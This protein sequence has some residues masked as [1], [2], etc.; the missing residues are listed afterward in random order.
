V[1]VDRQGN[2]PRPCAHAMTSLSTQGFL[3]MEQTAAAILTDWDAA[4][5]LASEATQPTRAATVAEALFPGDADA[6]ELAKAGDTIWLAMVQRAI[7]SRRRE[8]WVRV[9]DLYRRSC[10]RRAEEWIVK[11]RQL[12][13]YDK[14]GG[15]R[16]VF[17]AM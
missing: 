15:P 16:A 5:R 3:G 2:H 7:D 10:E 12:P 6:L 14:A 13:E 8:V 17:A 4:S 1:N 9:Q 11:S